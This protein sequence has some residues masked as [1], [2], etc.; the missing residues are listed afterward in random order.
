MRHEIKIPIQKNFDSDFQNL[1]NFNKNI[2]RSFK[3]RVINSIYFD[4][5]NLSSA[6]NNLSGISRRSKYRI[7]WYNDDFKNLNYEIKSKNNNLG[8]KIILKT[9]QGLKDLDSLYSISNKFLNRPENYFFLNKINYYDLKP[10]VKI[11]YLRSYY[12]YTHKVML[13]YDKNLKYQLINKFELKKNIFNDSMNVIEV[14]FNKKDY[15]LGSS[16]IRSSNFYPK[17]F[18]KYLRSLYSFNIAKYL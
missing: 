16:L 7:R 17:R 3:D 9:D 8:K 18:S 4:T 5:E 14:K 12:I 13:T 1:I 6:Q 11:S 10:V 2:K 15:E